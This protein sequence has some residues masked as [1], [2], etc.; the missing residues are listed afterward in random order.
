MILNN[1]LLLLFGT[2]L[3]L[4]LGNTIPDQYHHFVHFDLFELNGHTMTI[5][6]LVQQV[7][8]ALFFG[9]VGKEIFESFLHGGA[10]HGDGPTRSLRIRAGMR[11]G[12]LP[13]VATACGVLGPALFFIGGTLLFD[14][15][16]LQSAWAIPTATD[17]AFAAI[18][19]ILVFGDK[20]HP[21]VKFL[22]VLAVVD[23][24]IGLGIIAIFYSES[25]N[26]L[27]LGVCIIGAIGLG[28]TMNKFFAVQEWWLYILGPGLISWLGFYLSG[29]EAALALVPVV[30][31]MPHGRVDFGIFDERERPQKDTLNQFERAV[32]WPV[33]FTLMFFGIVNAG[34][35]ISWELFSIPATTLVAASL[36]IG[37]PLGIIPGTYLGV[38]A[39]LALP[40]GMTMKDVFYVGIAASI[41]MTVA[42]FVATVA[43]PHGIDQEGA[44]LGALCSFIAFPLCLILGRLRNRNTTVRVLS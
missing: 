4:I 35:P 2:C 16:Y 42:I 29:V 9:V 10:F 13:L 41:G 43:L 30:C 12:A 21:A 18:A 23:D 5:H 34:V 6:H 1:Y 25:V 17:I 8:M 22:F 33:H 36:L 31:T 3:G 14:I 39:G 38:K 24:A 20:G 37:K 11:N 27:L 19:A 44:K 40:Q 15:E 7:L 32:E 26:F 28:L